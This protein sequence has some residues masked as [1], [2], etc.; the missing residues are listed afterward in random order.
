MLFAAFVVVIVLGFGE[1][2]VVILRLI[3]FVG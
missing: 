3:V 1:F 2:V